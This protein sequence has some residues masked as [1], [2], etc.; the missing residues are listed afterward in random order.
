MQTYKKLFL[1]ILIICNTLLFSGCHRKLFPIF[2]RNR[3]EQFSTSK[4]FRPYNISKSENPNKKV[5]NRQERKLN[6]KAER[7][8]REGLKAQEKGR[9][10]HVKRQTP[11]VQERMKRSLNE[12]EKTRTRRTLWQ[13]LKSWVKFKKKEKKL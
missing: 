2:H 12:S 6:R 9:R 3:V 7:A 4:Q 1:I 13:R 11:K 10:E 5:L 8:K